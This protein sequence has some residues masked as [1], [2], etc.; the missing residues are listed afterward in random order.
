MAVQLKQESIDGGGLL[1]P[2]G[3]KAH[4]RDP[5]RCAAEHPPPTLLPGV[6]GDPEGKGLPCPRSALD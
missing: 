3:L 2:L 5:G 6:T 1:E 4:G